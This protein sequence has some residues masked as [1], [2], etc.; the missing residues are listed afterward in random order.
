LKWFPAGNCFKT[1]SKGKTKRTTPR[2]C[3]FAL[4][5]ALPPYFADPHG[6]KEKGDFAIHSGFHFA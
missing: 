2:G 4:P 1:A 6:G 5:F 3:E